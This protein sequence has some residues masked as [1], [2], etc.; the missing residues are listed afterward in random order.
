MILIF[1]LNDLSSDC[2]FFLETR[3]NIIL[4]GKFTKIIYSDENI[5]MN[6]IYMSISIDEYTI[7]KPYSRINMKYTKNNESIINKIADIERSIIE[8]FK[9]INVSTKQPKYILKE[10]LDTLFIKVYRDN[11]TFTSNTNK[12]CKIVLKISGVWEDENSI[13]ITYKFIESFS[14]H[15]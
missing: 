3:N 15:I 1:D 9:R 2:V 12:F 10:Q 11:S 7:D 4:D 14:L 13:G 8:N 6:G 5:V